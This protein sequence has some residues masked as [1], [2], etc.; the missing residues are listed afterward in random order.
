MKDR[1][2]ERVLG[3]PGRICISSNPY[4]SSGDPKDADLSVQDDPDSSRLARDALVLGA[5]RA[6]NSATSKATSTGESLETAT[7]Q[8][9]PHQ[10]GILESTRVA[11]R[12]KK[13][14][15]PRFSSQVEA[16]IEAPQRRSSRR[17]YAS[18]WSLFR[19]WC[20]Q[21]K[22]DVKE[23]PIPRI[24]D[25]LLHLFK[26]K[27]LKPATI[28]GYKTAIADGL[29]SY[30]YSVATNKDLNRLMTSFHR[31]R[32]RVDRHIP[33]WDLSLVLLALTKSPFEPLDKASLKLLTFK[34]I[35]LLALASGKRRSEI[36][37]WLYQ[38]VLFNSND[39]KL[40]VSPCPGFLAKNQ[41]ASEGPSSVQPV[42]IPAL[43]PILGPDLVED[44][45][46]CP[47]RCLKIYI[48]IEQRT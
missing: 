39:T 36:H 43:S 30:G 14:Q 27:K 29:G 1:W 16:R 44:R 35:F 2:P 47:I 48:L 18:R 7:F 41:L 21:G 12:L 32:P 26:D 11:P 3:S 23:P 42:V 25:F 45:S 5:D 46:L 38:S 10:S 9:I 15:P 4:P 19:K 13:Y 34:T 31:D 17:V 33:P 24:A 20:K 28:A 37:S 40:T 8:Q 22:V 6:G